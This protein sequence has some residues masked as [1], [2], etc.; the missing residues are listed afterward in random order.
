MNSISAAIRKW[1]RTLQDSF[2]RVC[3]TGLEKR[4]ELFVTHFEEHLPRDSKVLDIGGGWGF[5]AEPLARLGHHVTVLDVV[6]PGFQKVP[7]VVYPGKD[8]PFPDKSFDASLLITVLHHI[9]DLD[10]VL[11]EARRVTRNT[12][13]VVEDLYHHALGRYWTVLRDKIYNFEFWGHPCCFKKKDEWISLFQRHGFFLIEQKNV[14]TWLAGLRILNGLFV[15][16]R[17]RNL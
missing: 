14:Y 9:A 7:V 8:L 13:I 16:Q 11:S 4:A 3:S 5:Y 2:V 6:K 17:E 12:L 1:Q 10:K 15:F